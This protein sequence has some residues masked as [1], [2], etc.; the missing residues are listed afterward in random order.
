MN[1]VKAAMA[2]AASLVVGT[3]AYYVST[4]SPDVDYCQIYKGAIVD[5]S[6]TCDD[7]PDIMRSFGMESFAY[8]DHKYLIVNNGNELSLFNIDAPTTPTLQDTSDYGLNS[9]ASAYETLSVDMCDECRFGVFY[10]SDRGV[11]IFDFGQAVL[12]TFRG[13]SVYP[14]SKGHMTFKHGDNQYVIMAQPNNC[15]GESGLFLVNGT[16]DLEL[17][18]CVE[19]D[20]VP[21][22]VHM[23]QSLQANDNTYLYLGDDYEGEAHVYRVDGTGDQASL[24]YITSP[25]KMKA[26]GHALSIDPTKMLA[27][28]TDVLREENT[29]V[30]LWD[31]AD[32][33][34]PV[35]MFGIKHPYA[36]S[37]YLRS[38]DPEAYATLGVLSGGDENSLATY[39]IR[40]SGTH[41][42]P[43]GYWADATE[44]HN[45]SQDCVT[46]MDV[47]LSVDGLVVYWSRYSLTQV[48]DISQ[49][50]DFPTPTPS[51]TPTN[52][53]TRT[54]GV[55]TPTAVPT[56]TRTPTP[57]VPTP[58]PTTPTIVI[59]W[60]QAKIILSE[61]NPNYSID[62]GLGYMNVTITNNYD[63]PVEI[64]RTYWEWGDQQP[65]G[66]YVDWMGLCYDGT[67]NYCDFDEYYW[68][69]GPGEPVR[70][71]SR[72]PEVIIISTP[73]ATPT[74][75]NTP[76]NTPG[77]VP[78]PVQ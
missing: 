60:S 9:G 52:T 71:P 58:T 54:P 15:G 55:G 6:A 18:E 16:S 17:L 1:A 26:W 64:T 70:L 20:G 12:P 57:P 11:V 73:T 30:T 67:E 25:E 62:Q 28:S 51:N 4:T 10:H 2:F 40:R 23:G 72:C 50:F 19:A 59:P 7:S 49:C 8:K 46:D 47:A 66:A 3:A 38:I 36:S 78:T 27:A 48:F 21:Y 63:Y 31:L 74:A 65:E 14:G 33:E 53:P 42:L 37:V 76:T 32:P 44:V 24:V 61:L 22:T 41:T 77:V 13:Y 35:E 34:N 69:S 43:N 56:S 75:T 29:I 39:L 5:S 45:T 68:Q